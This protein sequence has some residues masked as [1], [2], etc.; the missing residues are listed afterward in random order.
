[1]DAAAGHEQADS[2]H[3]SKKRKEIPVFPHSITKLPPDFAAPPFILPSAA[4][5]IRHGPMAASSEGKMIVIQMQPLLWF[6]KASVFGTI[7]W[8]NVSSGDTAGL[9]MTE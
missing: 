7:C 8:Y 3:C 9:R 1:M 6:K 2:D 5:Y 4:Y